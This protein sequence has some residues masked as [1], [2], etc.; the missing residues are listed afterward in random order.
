MILSVV[1]A[2]KIVTRR[3]VKSLL[4]GW[5]VIAATSMLGLAVGDHDEASGMEEKLPIPRGMMV[6]LFKNCCWRRERET[7]D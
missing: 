2:S 5:V 4:L 6:V 7:T 1:V 3:S